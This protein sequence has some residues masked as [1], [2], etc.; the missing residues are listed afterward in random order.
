MD[1]ENERRKPIVLGWMRENERRKPI[2]LGWMGGNDRR[3]PIVLGWMER[4]RGES[5]LSWDG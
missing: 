3:K 1:G 5:L 4:M 2:V